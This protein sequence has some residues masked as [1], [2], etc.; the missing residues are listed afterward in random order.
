MGNQEGKCRS[1]MFDA[2]CSRLVRR[3]SRRRKIVVELSKLWCD[4]EGA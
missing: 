3:P 2:D 1:V 4:V